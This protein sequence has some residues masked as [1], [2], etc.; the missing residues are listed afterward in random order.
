MKDMS[1]SKLL[2]NEASLD[3]TAY[4]SE[5]QMNQYWIKDASMSE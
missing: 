1:L 3:E 5:W 4:L 2:K